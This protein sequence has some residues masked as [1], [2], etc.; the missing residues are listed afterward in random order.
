MLLAIDTSTADAGI[1]CYDGERG[2]LGECVWRAGRDHTAQLLPQIDLLLRHIRCS[3]SDI[4][5]VA[6]ALGPG[7]WSGLR[8]GMSVAK[9]FALAC[10]LPLI[11]I[12]TLQ[13]L[14]YQH[15]VSHLRVVPIISLGRGRVATLVKEASEPQNVTL[16]DLAAMINEPALFCGDIDAE[17]QATLR[18]LL[19]DRARFPSPAANVRRPAYLAELAWMRLAAGERDSVATLEPIYL[20]QPVRAVG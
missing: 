10:D 13:A 3:R 20:G 17:T 16:A 5:A 7:S 9:G 18:R 11:G 8:V 12:G 6:V 19:H 1:A 14:A 15:R 4:Q 2:A